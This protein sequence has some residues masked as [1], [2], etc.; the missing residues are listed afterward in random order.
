MLQFIRD[1]AQG[2]IAW[3]IIGLLIIPFAFWGINTYFEGGGDAVVANVDGTDVTLNEYR[4]LM[5]RQRE[6]VRS[7]LGA[8]ATGDLIDSLVKPKDVLEA[9]VEREVLVQM[10]Q[11]AGFRVSDVVLAEQ[12]RTM[13]GFQR[14]GVFSKE[15]Y[16]QAL[17]ARGYTPAG[18]ENDM[19]RGIVLDQIN[20][21]IV[22]TALITKS[23]VDA[24]IRLRDQKREIGYAIVASAPLAA[25][26]TPS[27]E[28]IKKYYDE[29]TAQFVQP[30][31]VS[32]EY[33]ELR[34]ADMAA[35]VT[36]S[37]D[38]LK[39]FYEE[40]K[41]QY[42]VPEERRARHI[43]VTIDSAKDP[44]GEA[45]LKTAQEIAAQ[46]KKG[47]SFEALAK[48][49]SQDP[50]SA[51]QGGDLGFFGRGAMDPAFEAAAFA[52]KPGEVSEP[53]K[54][55]FGYHIIR[56]EA[57]NASTQKP[58]AEVRAEVERQLRD[59]KAQTMFYEQSDTLANLAYEK[60]DSLQ[61]V[62][63]ALGLRI[64]KTG[65]FSKRGGA[66]VAANPKVSAAAFSDDVLRK[67]LNS[68]PIEAGA[69]GVDHVVV[70]RVKDHKPEQPLT[71]ETVRAEVTNQVKQRM[72]REK[73]EELGKALRKQIE[74]GADAVAAAKE[75]RAEWKAGAIISRNDAALNRE[76]V[77]HAFKL[78][79]PSDGKPT[80]SGVVLGN[81]DFAVVSV[82]SV[83]D[84]DPAAVDETQRKGILQSLTNRA[85]ES[86]FGAMMESAKQKAKIA[87]F[88]DKL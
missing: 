13:E 73:S 26:M 20:S 4:D 76:V 53:V 34:A 77:N 9:A 57:I 80:V 75:A 12:I 87:R 39:Q 11:N 21:G 64:Q 50:G 8:S 46:I 47:E 79:K 81:G 55:A 27:E 72:A 2:W 48:A 45:A 59:K 62:A 10:G 41:D 17:R 67:G 30:E 54:S 88:E 58:F 18:F 15:L 16:Q 78:A 65:M 69:P 32:I 43:L 63:D 82:V 44:N 49:K 42:G 37:E 1:R 61:P 5:A 52:L 85:S 3:A 7:M 74:A 84:G 33:V 25:S 31:E 28:Q 70:L 19:K 24:Y 38:E 6:R 35:K 29:H 23:E 66:G 14:D 36:V 71:L 68:E 22:T 86:E 51:T 60:P 83:K 40:Q 56:L